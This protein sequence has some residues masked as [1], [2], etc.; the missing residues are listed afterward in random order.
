MAVET[1]KG[2]QTLW[3]D[4]GVWSKD[5]E[6]CPLLTLDTENISYTF[7]KTFSIFKSVIIILLDIS[8]HM[9]PLPR[10]PLA[11]P[12]LLGSSPS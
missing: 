3:A 7:K 9:L 1:S 2:N 4:D 6:S 12:P 11:L 5:D 8:S 10:P